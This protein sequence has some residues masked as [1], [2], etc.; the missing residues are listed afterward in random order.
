MLFQ[1]ILLTFVPGLIALKFLGFLREINPFTKDKLWETVL[2]YIFMA[3]FINLLTY[4]AIFLN[5][6]SEVV[7]F[8]IF[9]QSRLSDAGFVFKF[10]LI[11]FMSSLIVAPIYYFVGC[12][13]REFFHQLKEEFEK[14][15]KDDEIPEKS[16]LELKEPTQKSSLK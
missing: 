4:F 9:S 13:G 11:S 12:H 7:Y 5:E 6:P 3:F 1:F 2:D 15:R 8:S 16:T 14:T 10:S